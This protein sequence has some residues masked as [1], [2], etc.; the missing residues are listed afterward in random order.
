MLEH[1]L[2]ELSMWLAF[3]S[4]ALAPK[5]SRANHSMVEPYFTP[6]EPAYRSEGTLGVVNSFVWIAPGYLHPILVRSARFAQRPPFEPC[7]SMVK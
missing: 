2:I 4:G 3:S 7:P 1:V 6:W 5:I